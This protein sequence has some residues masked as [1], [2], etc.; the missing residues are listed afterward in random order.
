VFD[1]VYVLSRPRATE[2]NI[3]LVYFIY[4]EGFRNFRMG[5]ASA[6]A[7]ILFVIAAGLTIVYFRAQKRWVHYQ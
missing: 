3:T 4:E 2:A 6:A 7:W 1:Q 5:S